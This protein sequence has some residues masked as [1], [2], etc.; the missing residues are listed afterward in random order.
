MTEWLK[1][2]I[3]YEVYPQSFCDTNG[4]GIGDIP[5]IIKKLDYIKELGCNAIWINPCFDSPFYD[6]GYDVSDFYTVAPRYGTNEDLKE[7]FLQAHRKGMHVL[8][9][10]IPGHTSVEHPWFRES[11]KAERNE[12]TDR[13]VWSDSPY[14]RM[15]DVTG[16]VSILRGISPRYGTCG[17]NCFSTQPALNYGFAHITDPDWQQRVDAPGPMATREELKNIMRFWLTMGCDGFR[18]DMAGSLVK[19]DEDKKENI[20]L[21]Q[22]IRSFMRQEFPEAVLVS[23]WGKPEISLE[24]GFDMDFFLHFGNTGYMDLFRGPHPFFG[25]SPE[26]DI[27]PFVE[28]Y[29]KNQEILEG[30]GMMCMPSGNHDMARISYQLGEKQLMLAYG[31]LY[32]FPGA[33]F[34]YYGDEIGMRYLP[35]LISV[36]GAYERTGSRTPMQWEPGINGGFS[37]ASPG[38]LYIRMDPDPDRPNVKEQMEREDSLYSMVRRLIAL[39][40][41]YPALGNVGKVNFTYARKGVYPLVFERSGEWENGETREDVV[42]VL[43]PSAEKVSCPDFGVEET[44]C[45]IHYGGIPKPAGRGALAVPPESFCWLKRKSAGGK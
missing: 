37:S 39:R 16:I 4:D 31:F 33:P 10:L 29:K 22:G 36:E 11:M 12:Y 38:K 18:V 21:W 14:K 23:E 2:A 9:D 8:L 30:K 41:E 15:E 5:G 17:V 26:S 1:H 24:A 13:Y 28:T 40:K 34:L 42:I 20:R 27:M 35:D 43:N 32:A 19:N 44:E 3:F 7:L 6:G 45:L 25:G